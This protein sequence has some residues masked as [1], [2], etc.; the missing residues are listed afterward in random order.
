RETRAGAKRGCLKQL[1]ATTI[2]KNADSAGRLSGL[3][4]L[5]LV[6]HDHNFVA[7]VGIEREYWLEGD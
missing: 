1:C 7:G 6:S 5:L 2:L 3:G 4:T